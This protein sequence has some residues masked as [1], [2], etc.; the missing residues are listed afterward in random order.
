MRRYHDLAL[1]TTLL[2][3]GGGVAC[4]KGDDDSADN[5]KMS[6]DELLKSREASSNIH[7]QFDLAY[8]AMDKALSD[9]DLPAFVRAYTEAYEFAAEL[10]NEDEMTSADIGDRYFL[11]TVLN[12]SLNGANTYGA[13]FK[14]ITVTHPEILE[15]WPQNCSGDSETQTQID[16]LRAFNEKWR[17]TQ[18]WEYRPKWT[19]SAVFDDE[20]L[21]RIRN[22]GFVHRKGYDATLTIT[23]APEGRYSSFSYD[24]TSHVFEFVIAD[25]SRANPLELTVQRPIE[26]IDLGGDGIDRCDARLNGIQDSQISE[27]N[28]RYRENMAVTRERLRQRYPTHF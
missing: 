13:L 27:A 18:E 22:V 26:V 10:M 7:E 28:A 16:E 6:V 12:Q 20:T 1:L 24:E 9:K 21:E 5:T 17:K 11:N 4:N 2:I 19:F 8:E 25:I 15:A 14:R 3:M 23:D